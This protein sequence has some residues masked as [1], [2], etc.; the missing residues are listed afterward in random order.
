MLGS[1]NPLGERGRRSNWAVTVTAFLVGS[2]VAG[3]AVGLVLGRLGAFLV[4]GASPILRA[5]ITAAL[6]LAAA[7]WDVALA[8]RRA[9]RL[10]GP[11][12]QVNEDWLASYRGWVYGLAFGVQLGL[13]IATIVTT[14][15]VYAA[16]AGAF[17]TASVR[18]GL[19]VG[20]AFGLAR[21]LPLLDAE[22]E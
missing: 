9:S 11:R 21:A 12:R 13:G 4:G 2:V 15:A 16:L 1:I 14:S 20:A 10:P 22:G 5:A 7:A 3:S 8:R 18:G 6:V 17:L 19:V